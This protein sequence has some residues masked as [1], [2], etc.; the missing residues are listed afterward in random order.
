MR[1]G[2]GAVADG[3][4]AVSR[5][6]IGNGSTVAT[7]DLRRRAGPTLHHSSSLGKKTKQKNKQH[8]APLGVTVASP[9]PSLPVNNWRKEKTNLSG[10]TG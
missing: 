7:N 2:G 5:P 3:L 8:T 1:R 10:P 4:A 9:S 6:F